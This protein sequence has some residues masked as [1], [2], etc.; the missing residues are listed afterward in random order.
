MALAAL[1]MTSPGL[2]A[3]NQTPVVGPG[4]TREEVIN[5]YGWPSGLSQAGTKEVLTY[6]Q[7]RITLE[8]G[9][10]ERVDFLPNVPWPA[11]RPRPA[12]PTSSTAKRADPMLDFWLERLD[13]AQREARRRNARILALFI[14]SDWSPPSRQFVDEVAFSPE[15]VNTFT[16]DFVFLRLDFPTRSPQPADIREQNARLREAYGVTTY[17]ALLVLSAAGVH[18]A[19]IDLTKPRAGDTYLARTIAAVAEIRDGLIVRPPPP[20]P[21]EAPVETAVPPAE[22][23]AEAAPIG[24]AAVASSM[25]SATKL[26]LGAIGVGLAMI[27]FGWW[28][29]WRPPQDNASERIGRASERIADAAS[30][31]PPGDEVLQWP[32]ERLRGVVARLAE[33]E[34]YQV[35]V[36]GGGGDGD[37]ALMHAGQT[38]PGVIVSVQPGEAGPA[39]AKRVRELFGTITVEGVKT[40]WFVSPAGFSREAREYAKQHGVELIETEH[41]LGQLRSAPPILLQKIL[42]G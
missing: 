7:G 4:A 29:L 27:A 26:I 30:G 33:V 35:Q 24:N 37:L 3:A 8:N 13:D 5:A 23:A 32:R 15:F 36:R 28:F 40:G 2:R 31:L 21:V 39:S 12:P 34:G 9:R 1:V 17:P 25:G 20:D 6:P 16:G 42:A 38:T 14:G 18:V 10:V 22:P 41:L 11:P 19:T